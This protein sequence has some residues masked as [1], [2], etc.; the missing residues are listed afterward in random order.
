MRGR[1]VFR[2]GCLSIGAASAIS[3][4]CSILATWCKANYRWMHRPAALAAAASGNQARNSHEAPNAPLEPSLPRKHYAAPSGRSGGRGRHRV[5]Q[6]QAKTAFD[7]S[8][9]SGSRKRTL[10]CMPGP[11]SFQCAPHGRQI[12]TRSSP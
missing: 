1:A 9:A 8:T 2:G 3:G 12:S 11:R 7:S 4:S 6:D 10:L 5:L